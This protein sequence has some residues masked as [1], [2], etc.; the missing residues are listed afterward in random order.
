MKDRVSLYPGRVK[1]IPVP[2]QENTFDQVRADQ[3]TQEGT[4]LSKE[5]LLKDSTAAVFGLDN[6]SLLDDVLQVLSRLHT[7]LGDDFLWRT[8]SISGVL[9]EAT[10]PTFTSRFPSTGTAYYYDSVQLDLANKKVVGIGEHK[11]VD[12]PSTSKEWDNVIGK[13]LFYPWQKYPWPINT[14]YRV[15]AR[16]SNDSIFTGYAQY[17]EYTYGPIQYLNSPDQDAY[18]NGIFNGIQYDFLGKIGSQARTNAGTYVGTGGFGAEHKCSLTFDFV[19][20][21]VIVANGGGG[22]A[23]IYLGQPGISSAVKFYLEDK[24]LFWYNDNSPANQFNNSGSTYYYVA[25]GQGD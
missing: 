11:I 14:F 15:T 20:K 5:T 17:V 4:P 12:Q 9:K 2:G 23:L 24:T 16:T 22:N 21:L 1:L 10:E 19:P 8:Q 3:P 6:N 18:P 7:H 25:I 13:Y